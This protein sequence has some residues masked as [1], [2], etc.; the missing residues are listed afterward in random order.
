MTEDGPASF[1]VRSEADR[2]FLG[3]EPAEGPGASAFAVT[4]HLTRPDGRL[5]GGAGIAVSV[6]AIEAAAGAPAL[7]ATAQLIGSPAMDERVH[8][9]AEVLAAGRRVQQVQ[10]T[11]TG[12]DGLA[13]VALG[14]AGE[15]KPDAPSA[16]LE[17]MPAV[18]GPSE[19]TDIASGGDRSP[20]VG[21]HRYAD[22]RR[23]HI[24]DHPDRQP[25]RM[26]FW[27]RLEVH[28][29]TTA[30]VL[31]FLADVVPLSVMKG[32]GLPG[33]GTS[34]DNTLRCGQLTDTGWVLA[35]IR[36]HQAHGGFGQGSAHLWAEDG[37]LLG[38]ASQTARLIVRDA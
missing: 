19:S 20:T 6:A 22:L 30:T 14:A 31:A 33:H 26:C 11:A 36:G 12:P 23:A 38:T 18:S 15:P 28:P 27:L 32:V 13:F 8:V 10:V 24:V 37:T 9:R 16:T 17:S 3:L 21:W 4:P 29:F 7:W 35:D 5:F 34:L 1:R 25:G 2:A